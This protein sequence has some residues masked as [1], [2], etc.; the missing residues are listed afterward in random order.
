LEDFTKRFRRD[1]DGSWECIASSTLNGPSGRI[2]VTQ[3]TR[4]SPGTLYMG[5]DLAAWLEREAQRQALL[6]RLAAEPQPKSRLLAALH[7]IRKSFLDSWHSR[8]SP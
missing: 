3:G 4:L 8:K 2:Q 6:G 7:R 1:P 5:V